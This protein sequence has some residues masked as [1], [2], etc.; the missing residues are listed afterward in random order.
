VTATGETPGSMR[1]GSQTPIKFG[2]SDYTP[3]ACR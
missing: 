2:T 3:E 1:A